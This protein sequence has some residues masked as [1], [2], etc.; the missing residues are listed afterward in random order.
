[1]ED[2]HENNENTTRGPKIQS[3]GKEILY[4][5]KD[6]H[7]NANNSLIYSFHKLNM[8]SIQISSIIFLL[9]KFHMKK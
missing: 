3:K 9:D 6:S 4:S 5:W 8:I 1:M 7:N 2:L